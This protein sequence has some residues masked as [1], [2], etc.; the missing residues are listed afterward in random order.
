MPP[1]TWEILPLQSLFS[2]REKGVDVTGPLCYIMVS[3][4]LRGQGRRVILVY[5]TNRMGE[6]KATDFF[7]PN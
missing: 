3:P 2:T 5:H 6:D 4:L 7:F 1:H